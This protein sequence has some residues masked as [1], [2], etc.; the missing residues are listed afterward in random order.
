MRK[1]E[2]STD[3]DI[4]KAQLLVVRDRFLRS[5]LKIRNFG[6]PIVRVF[7]NGAEGLHSPVLWNWR[8]RSKTPLERFR[9]IYTERANGRRVF[10]AGVDGSEESENF[11]WRDWERLGWG[12][13]ERMVAMSGLGAP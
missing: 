11:G 10:W 6:R 12:M 2:E 1:G 9:M 5:L 8:Y 4:A 7:E 3:R 13:P